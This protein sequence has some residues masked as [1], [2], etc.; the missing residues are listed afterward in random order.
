MRNLEEF[1][2]DA[3]NVNHLSH[4]FLSD[5]D[6]EVSLSHNKKPFS[7]TVALQCLRD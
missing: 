3:N 7:V 6:V 5:V 4:C 1:V 2:C